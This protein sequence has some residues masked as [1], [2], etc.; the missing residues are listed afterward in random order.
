LIGRAAVTT[1]LVGL[2][3]ACLL[4]MLLV[5]A[6]SF[7]EESVVFQDGYRLLPREFSI[8]AYARI[9]RGNRTLGTAYRNSLIVTTIGTLGAVTITGMAGYALANRRLRARNLFALYFFITMIFQ[10][11]IVPWYLVNTALGLQEN[12]LALIVPRLLFSAFNMFLVRNFMLGIPESLRE[13]ALM[14]GAN[15]GFIAFRIY[16]PLSLPVLAT[17]TL[18]YA[19]D[20]WNDWFNTI[21]L[22]GNE[23]KELH[24]L[25]FLLFR[26]QSQLEALREMQELGMESEVQPWEIPGE[27]LKMATVVLTLGPIL[28]LYPFLQRYFVKGLVVSAIKG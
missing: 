25:Q 8:E 22:V 4:P 24:P 3:L 15:D 9:F 28:L 21:M 27:S 19:I 7:T 20:Y 11:G 6:V 17:V 5:V 14:D 12:F 1:F 2:A 16:F 13:S 10:A 26:L 23:N 18:F